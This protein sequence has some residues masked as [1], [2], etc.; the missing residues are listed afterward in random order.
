MG[1]LSL[2]API[3]GMASTP[4]G[5]GS[6]RVGSDGGI[7]A[8]GD[9][10]F[11]GSLS[12]RR[13]NQPIVG[14]AATPT[15][16]GYWFVARDGGVFAFGDAKY[17]GS[18]GGRHLNQP[19]VA[20]VANHSGHGYW[21][22]ARDGGIFSF[23]NA[24]FYGSAGAIRL[25]QPIV[26][27]APAPNGRGY[28]FVARDGGVFAFGDAHFQGSVSGAQLPGPIVS[29]APASNG[30]GYLLLAATGRVY[31]FGNAANYGSAPRTCAGAPA[32]AI[33]TAPHKSGYWIAF[34]NARAYALTPATGPVKCA[35]PAPAKPKIG[36]AA[37]DF[38]VRLNAERS[39]RGLAPLTWNAGLASYALNWSKVMGQSNNLYHSNIGALLGPWDYVGEN[40]ATGSAGVN[41]G[42]LHNAWMHSPEHR[43]NILSPGYQSVG[44]GVYCAPNGSIWAT[45]EFARPTSAGSPPA[46]SGGTPQ[47]PIARPDSDSVSC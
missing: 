11:Y 41:V 14:M 43:D 46:Y 27:G 44:I 2:N 15:G 38:L 39:A 30:T 45:T 37:G 6:W 20:I 23:G 12:G 34:A 29:M 1:A 7:F 13:L 19:I 18:T 47:N 9:A 28:W 16:H 22:V 10:K 35:A 24:K 40:I 17:L 36:A 21:L 4:S 33:A 5:D 26:G 31:N 8:S 3:V 32:V 42:A 25:N